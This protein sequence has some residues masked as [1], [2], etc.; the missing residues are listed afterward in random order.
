LISALLRSAISALDTLL[1]R[2]YHVQE[3]T[4]KE[5]CILRIALSRSDREVTLSDGTRILKGE[6][7]GEL[8]LWNE[9]IPPMAKEGPDF[10][11][12][13]KFY[14][15]LTRSLEDLAEYVET[16]PKFKDPRAFRGETAFPM[17]GLM[18]ALPAD[19]RAPPFDYRESVHQ[20]W[21]ADLVKQL[22][23][24]FVRANRAG[25]LRRF[26]EF[27]EHLYTWGLIW[28]FNP[29]SLKAKR[30]FKLERGQLWISRQALLKIG[31]NNV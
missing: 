14:Y 19:G 22:G 9:H 31:A 18:N 7:I 17:G 10:G 27:W 5:N 3:F 2:V 28:T 25:K 29:G 20:G 1:R 8:H 21:D 13:L 4:Q 6:T 11:W 15:R 24:D 16:D 30:F 12:A 26:G 23:F